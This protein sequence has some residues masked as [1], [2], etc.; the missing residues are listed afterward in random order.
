[1]LK[2]GTK[3]TILSWAM[4]DF[5]NTIFAMN[6]ITL[7]FALWV[8]VD[9][10]GEDIL[11]SYALS[12]SMLITALTAPIIG[13]ISDRVG[14]RVP[15]LVAF[16]IICCLFTALIGV[17]NKLFIGLILFAIANYCYQ[18]SYVFYNAL[19][20]VISDKEH[21]GRVSG[22]GTGLGYLG[23]IAGLLIVSP[24]A[25]YFGRQATFIP[26]AICFLLFALPC[27]IF[28]KDVKTVKSEKVGEQ[29][30]LQTVTSAFIKIKNTILCIKQ[31]PGLLRFLIAA[32]IGLNAINT[33]Y[34]FMAVYTK[35]V[36][37]FGDVEI[38]VL[39]IVSSIFAIIGSLIAGFY[40]DRIGAKNTFMA[41]LGLWSICVLLAIFSFHKIIF[42]FIGP[43]AG[44][45][46]AGTWTSARALIIDLSPPEMIAEIFGFYSLVGRAASIVGPLIW[47]GMVLSFSFLGTIKY[48]LAIS[49]LLIFLCL[50][51]W[52]VRKV[53]N[54]AKVE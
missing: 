51:L 33:I 23:T 30:A 8:T 7:Y 1:M 41:V 39:Y 21:I 42:W 24:F 49:A 22:Y 53:P 13:A 14:K 52:I 19:L 17:T 25:L 34:I 20:P 4:Y 27:F 10:K 46:L 12:G 3:L 36:L 2:E 35:K 48:R 32:F 43:L 38:V 29:S 16:T 5:A 47:G 45:C 26:T 40:C 11:Y 18:M 31:Y 44:V 15:F 28:V 37:G 9:M 6:V 54:K 50:S